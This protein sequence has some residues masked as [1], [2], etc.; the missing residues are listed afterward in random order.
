MNILM[1]GQTLWYRNWQIY[2]NANSTAPKFFFYFEMITPI[3]PTACTYHTYVN[4][5][6]KVRNGK[7]YG[8][9]VDPSTLSA[10]FDHT[11]WDLILDIDKVTMID[12]ANQG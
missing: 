6:N 10:Q 1:D 12:D 5:S 9:N 7:V 8:T 2:N 11:N 3:A 4:D